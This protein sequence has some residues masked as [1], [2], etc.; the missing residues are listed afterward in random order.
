MVRHIHR[1]PV[2][3]SLAAGAFAIAAAPAVA[4]DLPPL[5]A[6]RAMPLGPSAYD[7]RSDL[8]QWGCWD[9]WGG[10]WGGGWGR[11]GW[12]RRGPSAGEVLAGV[13]II[14]GIAAIASAAN[15]NRRNRDVVVIER[16]RPQDWN[17]NPRNPQ[18]RDNDRR[19]NPR[20][21]GAGGL[22]GAVSQCLGAIERDVRVDAVEVVQRT[23]QGWL[24]GGTLFNGSGFECRIGNDGRIEAIDYGAG[25][26]FGAASGSQWDDNRYAA[27]RFAAG[28]SQPSPEG[29][30][31]MFTPPASA[32]VATPGGNGQQPLVP[33]TAQRLPTY[34][35]GPVEGEEPVPL[36]QRPGIP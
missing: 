7:A 25:G 16:D 31:E 33:L 28:P 5:D 2:F 4:A 9:C 12:R 34:P 36:V 11:G 19:N 3:A 23:A 27:A 1:F 10:G 30:I 6:A 13:A 24:V 17:R 22:D 14:G 26:A 20:A 35:G 18:W 8:N 15:N 21:S 32:A 29:G